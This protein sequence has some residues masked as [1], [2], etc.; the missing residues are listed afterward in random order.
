MAHTYSIAEA[1]ARLRVLVD[2]AEAG[3]EVELTRRGE[4]V[5]VVLSYREVERLR[6]KRPRFRDV[7]N[8]FRDKY[9]LDQVGLEDDFANVRD[10][11]TGRQVSV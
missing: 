1:R 11:G 4:P 9:S 10:A 8:R 6:G 7:Y 2:Q 5:A 3:L